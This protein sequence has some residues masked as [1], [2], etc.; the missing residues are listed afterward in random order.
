MVDSNILHF[1]PET[2]A[3]EIP[4]DMNEIVEYVQPSNY[5]DTVDG[6]EI[7][8]PTTWDV[9]QT[10]VNIGINYQPQ[11]VQDWDLGTLIG[12][13][14]FR[15]PN[16]QLAFLWGILLSPSHS[17]FQGRTVARW[18]FQTFLIFTPT[19]GNDPI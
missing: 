5:V 14:T 8:R 16:R 3:T 10:P 2:L 15:L 4:A 18:W 17:F 1:H 12:R 6:S 9:S 13:F 19:W 11:L 7:P